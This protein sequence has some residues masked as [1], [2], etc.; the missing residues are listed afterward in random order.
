MLLNTKKRGVIYNND[1]NDVYVSYDNCPGAYDISHLDGSTINAEN[2]LKPRSYGLENTQIGTVMYCDGVFGSYHHESVGITDTRVRC[3]ARALK[4]YTGK[5]SLT[6]MVDFVHSKDKDIIWSLRMNDVHDAAYQEN[7]LDPWKQAN[8]DVLMCRKADNAY[9]SYGG[10]YWSAV[11]Y[12]NPKVRQFVYDNFWDTLTRYDI[13]GIELDWTR[14]PIAFK[15]VTRGLDVYP[16][17]LERMNNLIRMI[18]DLTE[19]ISIERG[20]PILVSI[21]VPDSIGL[22]KSIGLDVET[23]LEEDL[24]DIVSIGCHNGICQTWEDA[25]KEYNDYDVQVYAALD[26]LYYVDSKDDYYVDKNEAALAYAAG[27]DGIYT[28]NYFDINHARFDTLGSPETVGS[29]DP[30]YKSNLKLYK[31][32]LARDTMKFVTR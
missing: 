25:V 29:V 9:M 2:F 22:C 4:E 15:E 11:D 31:G 27:A 8:M 19:Q 3:W 7:E 10:G 5:D 32:G 26:A 24:V 6:T 23:W 13:D 14:W 16:E 28:Y 20:K 21:Y 17:N 30:N 12:G 1:G 18:R